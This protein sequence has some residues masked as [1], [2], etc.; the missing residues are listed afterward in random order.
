MNNKPSSSSSSS[1]SFFFFLAFWLIK[2]C[3]S[4][5]RLNLVAEK[6]KK[7]YPCKG[8]L[9]LKKKNEDPGRR[10]SF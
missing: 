7:P 5:L 8:M 3:E 9:Q 1:S 4:R 2:S 10:S 6:K